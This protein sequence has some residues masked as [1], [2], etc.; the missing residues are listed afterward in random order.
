M[1]SLRDGLANPEKKEKVVSTLSTSSSE[2]HDLL[3]ICPRRCSAKQKQSKASA[4]NPQRDIAES[5]K[6]SIDFQR[7]KKRKANTCDSAGKKKP[8]VRKIEIAKEDTRCKRRNGKGWR[9]SG[10][11]VRGYSL[12]EHHL[13]KTQAQPSKNKKKRTT[14]ENVLDGS[15][16]HAPPAVDG[17]DNSAQEYA[18]E[19]EQKKART[20]ETQLQVKKQRKK[21]KSLEDINS[22]LDHHHH[23]NHHHPNLISDFTFELRESWL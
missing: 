7:G 4:S 19:Y 15:G 1:R 17:V 11:R 12:C 10:T 2:E 21:K 14:K 3:S 16:F 6:C 9:C 8:K 18:G 20:T 22:V 13:S 5:R 23:H